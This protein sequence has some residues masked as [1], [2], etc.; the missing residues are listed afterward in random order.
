MKIYKIKIKNGAK[1]EWEC[2]ILFYKRKLVVSGGYKGGASLAIAKKL[3]KHWI[4][5]DISPPIAIKL[6]ERRL[7]KLEV[8][9]I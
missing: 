2:Y 4:G 8:R 9:V 3:G 5:I 7:E 1:A 6:L